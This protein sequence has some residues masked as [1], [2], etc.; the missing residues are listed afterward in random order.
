MLVYTHVGVLCNLT[1]TPLSF[2][3]K[4]LLTFHHW[5]WHWHW[6]ISCFHTPIELQGI[7]H[8]SVV[9]LLNKV[10]LKSSCFFIW[11]FNCISYFGTDILSSL[12]FVIFVY[13]DVIKLKLML[14]YVTDWIIIAMDDDTLIAMIVWW[15]FCTHTKGLELEKL[16]KFGGLGL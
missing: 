1:H 9:L 7:F 16:L 8:K 2:R 11:P 4:R 10:L 14:M 3:R 5:H 15:F 6:K 12:V 13:H